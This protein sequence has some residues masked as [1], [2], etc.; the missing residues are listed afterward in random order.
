MYY[1]EGKPFENMELKYAAQPP[2]LAIE[3]MSPHDT[4][5]RVVRRVTELI[6]A[7]VVLVWVVDPET[8]N[9]SVY[10]AGRSPQLVE[11]TGE[12]TGEDV[13]EGFCCKVAELFALP[14]SGR[15]E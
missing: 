7:G 10:R 8:Q 5:N 11:E 13:L 14:G 2:T 15:S 4:V 3:V 1:A 6:D 9:V 12:L